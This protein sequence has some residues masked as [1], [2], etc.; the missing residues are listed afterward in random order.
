MKKDLFLTIAALLAAAFLLKIAGIIFHLSVGLFSF[1]GI[2]ASSILSAGTVLAMVSLGLITLLLIL[3]LLTVLANRVTAGFAELGEK[4]A[5]SSEKILNTMG[6][7]KPEHKESLSVL[8]L[9]IISELATF[10]LSGEFDLQSKGILAVLIL[11]VAGVAHL[12]S[13][14]SRNV[15]RL[16]K[17]TNIVLI[18]TFLIYVLTVHELYTGKGWQRMWD[19][20]LEFT[21]MPAHNQLG[22]SV[23]VA[24]VLFFIAFAAFRSAA[25]ESDDKA[26]LASGK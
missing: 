1:V 19:K 26:N 23:V 12:S 11:L 17:A 8:F 14:G 21:K 10:T 3:W 16:A 25:E 6:A 15:S 18:F 24:M 7:L 13:S 22:F 5:T 20:R 4:V 9:A 2:V